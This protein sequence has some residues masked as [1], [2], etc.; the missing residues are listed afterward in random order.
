MNNVIAFPKAAKAQTKPEAKAEPW[1]QTDA[2]WILK[3][4]GRYR[5]ID[6]MVSRAR[7]FLLSMETW[8]D[9]PS[10]KQEAWLIDLGDMVE[11]R[12]RELEATNDGPPA[13]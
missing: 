7:V 9:Q 12:L 2:G 5:S 13:A 10:P 8:P 3:Q 1:W 4:A 6:M 11:D